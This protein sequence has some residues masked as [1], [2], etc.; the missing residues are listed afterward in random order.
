MNK[1]STF[2]A[3]ICFIALS[4]SP[5]FASPKEDAVTLVEKAVAH[6]KSVGKE[7]ALADIN[8][9]KGAF[10]KGELYVFA[11]N[12]KGT[13]IAHPAN[14]KLVGK[15]MTEVKDAD[16]KVFTTEFLATANSPAGKGWVD[17]SWSN[18]ETKKIAPKS[19]YIQKVGDILVGC[20]IYK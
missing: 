11:Y 8:D 3:S 2:I 1:F 6:Y 4:L 5:A 19:S 13:I 20:G 9:P 16:G 12:L 15:D 7:K 14:P 18:P 10:I 17:Y